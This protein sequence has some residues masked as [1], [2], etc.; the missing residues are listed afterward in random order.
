MINS[1]SIQ[2]VLVQILTGSDGKVHSAL[3]KCV[4][5]RG[6][7]GLVPFEQKINK[8]LGEKNKLRTCKGGVVNVL[9]IAMATSQTTGQRAESSRLTCA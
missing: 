8:H 2:A 1:F 3:F 4:S 5:E 9:S 7:P 6:L